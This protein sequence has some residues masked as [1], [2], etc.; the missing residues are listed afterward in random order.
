MRNFTKSCSRTL[1]LLLLFLDHILSC[2]VECVCD[3]HDKTATCNSVQLDTVPNAIPWFVQEVFLQDNDIKSV[4]KDVFPSRANLHKLNFRNNKI[5]S[6]ADGAFSDQRRLKSIVLSYN[7]LSRIP[8]RSL[9]KS[10]NL[11][12]L[13]LDHNSIETIKSNSFSGTESLEW[14]QCVINFWSGSEIWS[15]LRF[16]E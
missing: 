15:F 8:T 16:L 7:V 2:P 11:I 3:E 5:K 1:Y 12:E 10:K 9:E 13:L 6:I 14:L 4:P